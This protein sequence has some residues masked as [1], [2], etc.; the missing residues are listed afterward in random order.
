MQGVSDLSSTKIKLDKINKVFKTRRQTINALS[1]IDIEVYDNE[2]ISIVGPSGCGKSTIIRIINDIIKPTS[3]DV[4]IDEERFGKKVSREVIRKMGFI[5][6]QPNLLPWLTVKGNIE[7]PLKVFKIYDKKSTGKT[8]ELLEMMGLKEYENAYPSELS[9]G[10][11]QRV[12]VLR[13]MIH[14]PEILLMDEPFGSLDEKLREQMDLKL[15]DIWQ[16]LHQTIVFITHNIVE[17]ILLASRIY[18]MNTNPG[19]VVEVIKID[20]PYPRDM[21]LLID[22]KFIEYQNKIVNLIGELH[23]KE[24]K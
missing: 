24:I 5:F 21:N 1:D 2:F 16:K 6:Q 12:G 11:T 9:G 14:E 3:G 17:A 15:L 13:A 4:Y 19:R 20:F 18:V 22:P 23:L 8:R 10:M 7:L